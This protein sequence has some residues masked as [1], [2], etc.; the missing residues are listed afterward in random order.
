MMKRPG[1]AHFL[2]KR[3]IM[4][5]YHTL[6]NFSIF[7]HFAGTACE[8]VEVS[9]FV[10][11]YL[12]LFGGEILSPVFV[13]IVW[14]HFLHCSKGTAASL[15]FIISWT[16]MNAGLKLTGGGSLTKMLAILKHNCLSFFYFPLSSCWGHFKSILLGKLLT[17][18]LE[19][20]TLML[21]ATGLPTVL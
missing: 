2:K 9:D 11:F 7:S 12:F 8:A 1:R 6:C 19:P 14:E 5:K 15:G 17:T 3:K 4:K 10:S 18:W 20:R 16:Q 13:Q 21:K